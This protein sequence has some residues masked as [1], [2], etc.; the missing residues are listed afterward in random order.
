MLP[1]L[2]LASNI[3]P[4]RQFFTVTLGLQRLISKASGEH[5]PP[6]TGDSHRTGHPDPV[7]TLSVSRFMSMTHAVMMVTSG[8]NPDVTSAWVP[9]AANRI[10]RK[11]NNSFDVRGGDPQ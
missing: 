8:P 10:S 2:V 11:S 1:A 3:F 6:D 5:G 4:R 9:D 7:A